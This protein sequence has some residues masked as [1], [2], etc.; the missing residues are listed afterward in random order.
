MPTTTPDRQH[1]VVEIWHRLG[2]PPLLG[3][4]AV[5]EF[6]RTVVACFAFGYDPWTIAPDPLWGHR[7]NATGTVSKDT[8]R[9][10]DKAAVDP[11]QRA[12]HEGWR[13]QWLVLPPDDPSFGV[14]VEPARRISLPSP[15]PVT[16]PPSPP[17][18]EDDPL[19]DRSFHDY[20]WFLRHK[21]AI[22]QAIDDWYR[23]AHGRDPRV[24]DGQHIQYRLGME[25]A[26]FEGIVGAPMTL[27]K[28]L[29]HTWPLH[30]IEDPDT[31]GNRAR[32]TEP[33]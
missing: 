20:Q 19:L 2:D 1:E 14:G 9:Y 29:Q 12:G 3:E 33:E 10:G 31:P 32:D 30:P 21:H 22:A 8:L 23:E 16:P 7:K 13:F 15:E 17:V 28:I 4:D 18:D 6:I 11:I 24:L 27:R 25:F 5:R 26:K